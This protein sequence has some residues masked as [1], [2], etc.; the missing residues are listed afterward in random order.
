[1]RHVLILFTLFLAACGPTSSYNVREAR[2]P[3]PPPDVESLS[4]TEA[5]GYRIYQHDRAAWVAT[6]VVTANDLLET[7]IAGYLSFEQP[8]GDI[9]VRFVGPCG[10][11]ICSLVDVLTRDGEFIDYITGTMPLSPQE[12]VAWQARQTAVNTDFRACTPDYN[13]VVLPTDHDNQPAW[14]VYLLAATTQMDVVVLGGHHRIIV[15][16][17]GQSVLKEE[18]LSKA[19]MTLPVNDSVVAPMTTHI[20]HDEP[21][22]TH[23]FTSLDYHIPLYVGTSKGVFEIK[24][25]NIRMLEIDQTP[26][27]NSPE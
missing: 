19:C 23:V 17:D 16:S 9:L 20:L 13:L 25:A 12:V 8:S 2:D 14:V 4:E 27:D 10:D 18:P 5:L 24:G 22:E 26:N 11:R 15:S 1:M 6:D 7:G 21:I 3:F